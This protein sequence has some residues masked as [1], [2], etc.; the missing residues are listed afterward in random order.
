M[1][2]NTS[3]LK[4]MLE[5]SLNRGS[6]SGGSFNESGQGPSCVVTAATQETVGPFVAAVSERDCVVSAFAQ[7]VVGSFSAPTKQTSL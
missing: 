3:R 7:E 2:E 5:R 1:F 6:L 4:N